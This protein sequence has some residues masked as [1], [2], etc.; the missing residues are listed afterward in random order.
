MAKLG[1]Q[2]AQIMHTVQASFRDGAIWL[3][4]ARGTCTHMLLRAVQRVGLVSFTDPAGKASHVGIA[5]PAPGS[6]ELKEPIEH[7][8]TIFKLFKAYFDAV[9]PHFE[10]RT[11]HASCA[12]SAASAST[13]QWQA[14]SA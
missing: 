13:N 6:A 11:S 9:F 5:W 4:E 1:R 2:A 3:P 8:K 7:A 12:T 10:A 14:Q